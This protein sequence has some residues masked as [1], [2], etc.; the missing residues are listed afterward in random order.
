[1]KHLS[2]IFQRV[3]IGFL[4]KSTSVHAWARNEG[5]SPQY[6][7]DVLYGRRYGPKAQDL[8]T[9]CAKSANVTLA[10]GDRQVIE[11]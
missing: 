8:R 11:R 3:Q 4:L 9:K 5:I 1:M 7:Y 10:A 6:I 2:N